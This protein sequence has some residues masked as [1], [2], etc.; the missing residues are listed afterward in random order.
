VRP[1]A[2]PID[3]AEKRAEQERQKVS[4][5][6][7]VPLT[8]PSQLKAASKSAAAKPPPAREAIP[9]EVLAQITA[10]PMKGPEPKHTE[11]KHT[12]PN[13]IEPTEKGKDAAAQARSEPPA[14]ANGTGAPQATQARDRKAPQKVEAPRDD[15]AEAETTTAAETAAVE[16][17]KEKLPAE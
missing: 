5:E 10:A 13:D 14:G 3:L 6:P 2:A 1:A 12:E 4:D 8:H 11:P 15:A 17:E 16:V 9:K 7:L